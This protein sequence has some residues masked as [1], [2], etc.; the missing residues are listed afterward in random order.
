M[1]RSGWIEDRHERGL[2]WR[3]RYRGP[4]GQVYSKSFATKVRAR[5]W[6]TDQLGKID[7]GRGIGRL[8]GRRRGVRGR[9]GGA[10]L[11]ACGEGERGGQDRRLPGQQDA[12]VEAQALPAQRTAAGEQLQQEQADGG[13]R[14]HQ[15]LTGHHSQEPHGIGAEGV[16]ALF[17]EGEAEELSPLLTVSVGLALREAVGA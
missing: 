2:R 7:D 10:A 14:Q 15:E 6:L 16:R 4:D 13:G 9:L 1:R 11:T 3:A 12:Q 17:G 8:D 5:R